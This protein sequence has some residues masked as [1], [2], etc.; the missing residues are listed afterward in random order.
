[1]GLEL[2]DLTQWVK[3]RHWVMRASK[4]RT[5]QPLLS[6]KEGSEMRGS[7]IGNSSHWGIIQ[8]KEPNGIT[9]Q[10]ICLVSMHFLS[11]HYVSSEI[12]HLSNFLY[13]FL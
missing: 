12:K 3:G 10:I 5:E 8:G 11:N 7:A 1:M 4:C 2:W 9:W 6:G 13:L